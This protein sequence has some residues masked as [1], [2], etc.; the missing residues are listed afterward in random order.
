MKKNKKGIIKKIISTTLA[1]ALVVGC[2]VI[3]APT[4]AKAATANTISTNAG[5]FKTGSS[6]RLNLK[7]LPKVGDNDWY[8]VRRLTVGRGGYVAKITCLNR[9]GRAISSGQN[10]YLGRPIA[11]G[12][13]IYRITLKSRKGGSVVIT[14]Y[15]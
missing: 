11:D 3:S 7:Y 2:L 9:N 15:Y 5:T 14:C 13:N 1:L 8:T 12:G 6:Y 10:V 4:E